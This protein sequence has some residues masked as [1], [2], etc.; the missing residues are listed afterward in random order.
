MAEGYSSID[1][2]R[3]WFSF[4]VNGISGTFYF[5]ENLEPVINS[6]EYVK[7]IF[8]QYGPTASSFTLI[9]NKGYQYIF[10]DGETSKP[11]SLSVKGEPTEAY[12]SGWFLTKIISPNSNEINLTYSDNRF[13]YIPGISSILLYDKECN[14]SVFP[15]Y[16]FTYTEEACL[17]KVYG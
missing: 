6:K 8:N 11:T 9:D 15:G 3:D 13:S 5:D 7:I 10:G 17:L 16:N 1:V 4:N 12:I 14:Q 2:E